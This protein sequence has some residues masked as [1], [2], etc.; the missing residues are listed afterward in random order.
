MISKHVLAP[1]A[2]FALAGLA[3]GS[4]SASSISAAIA[5]S[6][7]PAEDTA[8]DATRKPEA[9]LNFAKVH[10]GDTVLEVIPG[11][12]YF[13]RLLSKAVGP[14]GTVYAASPPIQNMGAKA[15]AIAADPHYANVKAVPLDASTLGP[16]SPKVD[17]IFTAQN[18]HDM[19][20][21]R[22]H[23]D[24]PL[25]DKY[26]FGKLKSGGRLIVID[27]IAADGAPVTETA[28][29]LHRIDPTAVLR[30][31]EGAGFVFDGQS[32]VLRNPNDTHMTIVFDPAIRGK[33]DQFVFR[34][35][36]P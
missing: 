23:Q 29:K 14:S 21:T 32:D 24:V 33:T 7:R 6:G 20:L 11:G 22:A 31:V 25:F 1:I 4:V 10:E 28:D 9:I 8:R 17:L 12:G 18:Y 5:D 16:D 34:F 2:A 36:K 27:H 3:A 30:E 26:L 13:T 19:H 35:R 15:E